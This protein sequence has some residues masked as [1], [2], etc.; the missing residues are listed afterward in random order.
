MEVKVVRDIMKLNDS[1]AASN[2][3]ELARRGIVTLNLVSSPGAG[4]T[5]L[6]EATLDALRDETPIGVVEG[7]VNTSHDAERIAAHG[8]PVVQVNTGGPAGGS[9]HLDAGMVREG[10]AALNLDGLDLLFIENVGNL[11]CTASFRLGEDRKVTFVSVTEGED[12]PVK[13]PLIFRNADA[14]VITKTDLIPHLDFEMDQLLGHIREVN[15]D[16]PVL[17]TSA[18]TGEGMEDWFRYLRETI[19]AVREERTA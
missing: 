5:R 13:Y 1:V 9:C 10:L 16:A 3:G 2:H 12:K 8:A 19:A 6:L 11:I 18:R 17:K 7:D 15:P 14:I 4:K